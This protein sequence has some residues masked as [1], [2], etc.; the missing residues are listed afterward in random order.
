M[1]EVSFAKGRGIAVKAYKTQW[2]V[3]QYQQQ[4]SLDLK[5]IL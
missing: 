3:V 2:M 4:G 1:T 5:T